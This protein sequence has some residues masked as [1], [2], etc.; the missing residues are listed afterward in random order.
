MRDAHMQPPDEP[1]RRV[2]AF[3]DKYSVLRSRLQLPHPR[4]YL[5]RRRR[6][7]QLA[8]KLCD[9][10]SIA[11]S[12]FTNFYLDSIHGAK[13]A[14]KSLVTIKK[15]CHRPLIDQLHRHHRLKNSGSHGNAK[16][17][18]RLVEFLVKCSSLLRRCR[19]N[20]TRTSLSA[21]VT[22]QRELRNYERRPLHLQQGPVHL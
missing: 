6:I 12:R 14:L 17:A 2:R 18:Q 21:R 9:S 10:P 1:N 5:T 13:P 7:S 22:V 8:R 3:R 20:K 4:G 16:P 11:P 19:G 15:N